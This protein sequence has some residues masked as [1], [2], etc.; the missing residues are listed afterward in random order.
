MKST[1]T[2]IP[3]VIHAI[4]FL[5]CTTAGGEEVLA[6]P[7]MAVLRTCSNIAEAFPVQLN[8]QL[9]IPIVLYWKENGGSIKLPLSSWTYPTAAAPSPADFQLLRY[10]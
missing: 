8:S 4:L 9:E 2:I 1:V 6:R 7:R 5:K 3:P 10:F